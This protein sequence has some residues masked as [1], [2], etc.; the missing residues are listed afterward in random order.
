MGQKNP[1]TGQAVKAMKRKRVINI[2]I[3]SDPALF[4]WRAENWPYLN[5]LLKPNYTL[6]GFYNPGIILKRS[7]PF[8]RVLQ[9]PE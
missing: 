8:S 9:R 5:I 2:L 7:S 4:I 3:V 1:I 6:S